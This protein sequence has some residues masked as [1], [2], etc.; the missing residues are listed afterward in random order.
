MK[1]ENTERLKRG[2]KDVIP[3]SEEQCVLAKRVGAFIHYWGF[4]QIHGE[5][6]SH[7][8]LSSR[9]LAAIEFIERLKLSKAAISLAIKDL[10]ADLVIVEQGRDERGYIVYEANPKLMDV[11]TRILRKREKL[12]LSDI[13]SAQSMVQSLDQ[14]ERKKF[15]I[16]QDRVLLMGKLINLAQGTLNGIIALGDISMSAW[17]KIKYR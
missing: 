11:I 12:M 1:S 17:L 13:L 14:N 4:K 9:P 8:Y 5:I 3:C 10:L 16:N 2:H 6:W 15:C 7:L